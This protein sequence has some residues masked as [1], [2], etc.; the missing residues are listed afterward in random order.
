MAPGMNI[1]SISLDSQ[2]CLRPVSK[3]LENG[4][5]IVGWGDQ[6]LELPPEGLQF[7]AWL[8]E[9]LS[10]TEARQRFE[11]EFNAFSE[12]EVLEVIEAFLEHDFI[13]SVDGEAIAWRHT[14]AKPQA[15]WIS[16]TW[17]RRI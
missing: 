17:A 6:C 5:A 7:I 10:L 9:G 15:V 4:V 14:P 2:I 11:V 13:A 8:N 1:S 12:A 3:Q 16:Q